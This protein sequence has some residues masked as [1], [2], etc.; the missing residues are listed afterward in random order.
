MEEERQN[1]LLTLTQQAV[2]DGMLSPEDIAAIQSNLWRLLTERTQRYTMGESS[3]VRMETAE[4]LFQS[5]LFSLQY[6]LKSTQKNI[7]CLKEEPLDALLKK[8][9]KVIE[10]QMERGKLLLKRVTETAPGIENISYR[11]TISELNIFFKQYDFRF[12]AHAIPCD[13]DY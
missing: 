7:A 4:S 6:Y 11:D 9:W 2:I 8:S 12:F 10:S 1:K 13:I 5:I 3:S